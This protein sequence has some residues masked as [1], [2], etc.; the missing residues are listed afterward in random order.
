MKTPDVTTGARI[1]A[2]E[3]GPAAS[4][5]G[6]A[7]VRQVLGRVWIDAVALVVIGIVFVVPFVFILFTAAKTRQEAALFQFTWPSEFQLFQNVR[8]VVMFGNYRMLRALWNSTLLTVVSVTLIVLCSAMVAY[9]MQRR[10]DWAATTA[11]NVIL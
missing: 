6:G 7:R 11:S 10:R 4:R 5:T 8:E 3:R 1:D 2:A 9:V